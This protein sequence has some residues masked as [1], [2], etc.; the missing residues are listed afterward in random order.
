MNIICL[1]FDNFTDAISRQDQVLFLLCM[2]HNND[3][4]EQVQALQD[5]CKDF[6]GLL[7]PGVVNEA[8]IEPFRLRYEVR[9]TPTFLI[10]KNGNELDRLLGMHSPEALV[11]FAEETLGSK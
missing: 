10:F 5:C 8:F 3:Y 11:R 7:I 6:D 4:P 9:G 1:G 2:P